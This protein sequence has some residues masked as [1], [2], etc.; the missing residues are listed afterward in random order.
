MSSDAIRNVPMI[1]KPDTFRTLID[2]L[3]GVKSF[4][5][6]MGCTEY[7]AKKMRDR[8]SI[9][10]DRWPTLIQVA[11]ERGYLFT[12]DDFVTMSFKRQVEKRRPK[13]QTEAAA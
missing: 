9:T 13:A 12:T 3:G 4:A 6:L 1:D 11:R 10:S 2:A 7:A 8:S 5:E